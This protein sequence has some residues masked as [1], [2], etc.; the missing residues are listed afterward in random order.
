MKI[1]FHKPPP[2]GRDPE[3]QHAVVLTSLFV[4][5]VLVGLF[6]PA[7]L[8]PICIFHKLTG[9]PCF[10]CGMVRSWHLLLGM[11]WSAAVRMQPLLV[12]LLACA[13]VWT[14]Y[15]WV[16]S[17]FRLPRLRI[18][19]ISRRTKCVIL[20][21]FIALVLVNWAYLIAMKI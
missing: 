16:V 6:L 5:A 11:E 18:E 2:G 12:L 13:T 4:L 14:S 15:G 1:H 7:R 17:L 3:F 20:W 10:S 8:T 9:L 19:D 21:G